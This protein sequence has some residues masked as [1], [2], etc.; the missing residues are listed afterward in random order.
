[1][2]PY[3]SLWRATVSFGLVS[4][5]VKVYA[6]A[7]DREI[8]LRQLHRRC[9]S[10]IQYRKWCPVCQ[11]A[12]GDEEVEWGYELAPGRFVVVSQ[13]E[14]EQLPGPEA[15][16]VQIL[17]FVAPGEVDPAYFERPYYLEPA[18]A[19][20]RAYRLLVE[21]MQ[22]SGRLAIARLAMRRRER[23]AALR[24][25]AGVLTLL[26]MRW[27]D[28]LRPADRVVQMPAGGEPTEREREMAVR[29]V[30]HL[31][32][33]FDPGR[34]ASQRRQAF[35]E[36]LERKVAGQPPVAASRPQP[37]ALTDLIEALQASLQ[38]QQPARDGRGPHADGQ[39]RPDGPSRP[40]G[41]G[42]PHGQARPQEPAAPAGR[43]RS[44]GRPR[45]R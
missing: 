37:T 10:P 32:A 38:A 4:I 14:M 16:V 26:T 43:R 25:A 2:G 33:P 27:A 29:L 7:E 11:A 8:H 28:E 17:D 19:A 13:Q 21:A 34:Y 41:A 3:R 42:E 36:L 40:G 12:V 5:P 30:E 23:L 39:L 6:A 20:V 45:A 24:P 35:A 31:S 44:G 18:E 15:H 1:M 22:R 9:H